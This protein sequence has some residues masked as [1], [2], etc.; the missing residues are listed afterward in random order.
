[1]KKQ[2]NKLWGAAFDQ[3]PSEAVI[4][5]A[6]GRDV[7]VMPMADTVLIP[8]DIWV[9]KA[10][11]V[12]LAKSGII[13]VGDAAKILSGLISLTKLSAGG[14]FVLDPAKEDVHTNIESWLT[15]KFGTE[16]AGKLHTARSRND[17]VVTD[18]RL[19][20]RDQALLYVKNAVGLTDTL[21]ALADTY[22]NLPM[23]GF[24]HHQHAMITTLG[25]TLIGF[26]SM[27]IRDI[28]RIEHW[29]ELHNYSPLGNIVSYGTTFAIDKTMTA[30]LLGFDGPDHN[31]LDSITNRWEAEADLA[32]AVAVL[33]NH[34]SSIA[35]TFILF[36]T[37]EFGM[38]TLSDAYSTG[39]SIM[40]QKKNPDPLEVIKGKAGF[41]QGQLMSLLSIGKSN[42]I[43]YHRDSQWTKYVVMDL[44]HECVPA[45]VVMS[46]VLSTMTVHAD[47]MASWCHK[48]F[49]GATTVMEQLIQSKHI[50]MREAK[51]T[52]EKMVKAGSADLDIDP[53]AA[54]S[55]TKSYGGP[56]KNSMKKSLKALKKQLSVSKKW[57]YKKQLA[58]VQAEK[59][60]EGMMQSIM[61]EAV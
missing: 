41:V 42:F 51:V 55:V 56:G 23:P 20:L 4:A 31:S 11:A 14:Q 37:P 30:K 28:K 18:M 17:Q 46:G 33:M 5:F 8:Y 21:L 24:T 58:K 32:F 50:P 15:E 44:V 40:P 59:K 45:P 16:V 61:K 53:M 25:H 34:L 47:A 10:H 29:Y 52:V 2:I 22:K 48:G 38:V 60:L 1:M 43:G 13:P 54:I 49:I 36:S 39:S 12:M 6:A 27:I 57:L 26:A 9:N 7:A 19:Y 35:E 3:Q